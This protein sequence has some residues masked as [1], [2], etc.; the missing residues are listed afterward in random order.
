MVAKLNVGKADRDSSGLY[1]VKLA[2]K[3]WKILFLNHLYAAQLW[4]YRHNFLGP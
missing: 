2:F 3:A 4:G 1:K